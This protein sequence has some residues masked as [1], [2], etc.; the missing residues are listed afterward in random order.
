V[1]GDSATAKELLE[2]AE[3]DAYATSLP[4]AVELCVKAAKGE[5]K[6]ENEEAEDKAA[7]PVKPK[8]RGEPAPARVA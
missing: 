5:L 7:K 1:K 8:R 2:A 6:V 4:E 3:V